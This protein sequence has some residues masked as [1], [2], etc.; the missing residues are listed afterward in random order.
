MMIKGGCIRRGY[1]RSN[2]KQL[3]GETT[4]T[5]EPRPRIEL[6]ALIHPQFFVQREHSTCI[7]AKLQPLR[8]LIRPGLLVRQ[9]MFVWCYCFFGT[10]FLT[11]CICLIF[12][13][14]NTVSW[15]EMMW[16]MQY[17]DPHWRWRP[18][19]G[20]LSALALETSALLQTWEPV[21]LPSMDQ[22][23]TTPLSLDWLQ[24]PR[25]AAMLPLFSQETL[26][27][28]AQLQPTYTPTS[29]FKHS[30]HSFMKTHGKIL[31]G[32]SSIKKWLYAAIEISANRF[33]LLIEMV[34]SCVWTLLKLSECTSSV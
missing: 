29:Q 9:R 30:H 6:Q 10:L 4:L 20:R 18:T 12:K 19:P 3:L 15:Y 28:C 1:R 27:Q 24:T 11:S 26:G 8:S 25:T 2:L 31:L 33:N 16:C 34:L 32:S 23:S 22:L 14:T 7:H 5:T 21:P 17:S 13:V